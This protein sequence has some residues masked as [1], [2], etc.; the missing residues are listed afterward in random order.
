MCHKVTKKNTLSV[1][2]KTKERTTQ[3]L[4]IIYFYKN[5]CY[6][7]LRDV[8]PSLKRESTALA[9]DKKRG[10]VYIKFWPVSQ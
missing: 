4:T 2:V 9:K 7:T 1:C 5:N 10:K 3:S 6:C 8:P